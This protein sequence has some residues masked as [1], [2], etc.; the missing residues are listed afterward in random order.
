MALN[1]EGAE[2]DAHLLSLAFTMSIMVETKDGKR[3]SGDGG[4]VT[5]ATTS[6]LSISLKDKLRM[7]L[8]WGVA[9]EIAGV[10]AKIEPDEPPR[11]VALGLRDI[12]GEKIFADI[13]PI[14][15]E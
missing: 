6:D 8:F 13:D 15:Q 3:P 1:K 5:S 9:I 4:N 7:R 10:E 11:G 2:K 12:D 14:R